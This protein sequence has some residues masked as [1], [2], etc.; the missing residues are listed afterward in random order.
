MALSD[1]KYKLRWD[2][3]KQGCFNEKCR[4]K[5]EVFSDCFPGR[6]N[7]SDVDG[8]VEINGKA[9]MLEWKMYFGN[10]PKGQEIMYKRLSA[11][12]FITVLCIVGNAE[13]MEC[14]QYSLF[15]NGKYYELRKGNINKIKQVIKKW[16]SWAKNGI[17][18]V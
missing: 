12:G 11:H 14:T 16:V 8:I 10:I 6:I 2:C 9:L 4:L 18:A 7:F 15:H 5:F 13:T 3:N 1:N 17:Y